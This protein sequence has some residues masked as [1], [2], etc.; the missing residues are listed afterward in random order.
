MQNP[1]TMGRRLKPRRLRHGNRP[2]GRA[3][4]LGVPGTAN[5]FAGRVAQQPL[6]FRLIPFLALCLALAGCSQSNTPSGPSPSGGAPAPPSVSVPTDQQGAPLLPDPKLTPGDALAGVA[7]SDVCV[8]GYTQTVRNVPIELKRQVYAE[9]GIMNHQPG[10]YEVDHLVSLELGG[11]NSI[12]NLWPQS[13]KTQPW[14]AHVKDQLENKL[15]EMICSGQIDMATAQHEIATDWI[16]AYKKYF[17]TDTPLSGSYQVH[18]RRH[19][20]TEE[21]SPPISSPGEPAA[22]PETTA[23]S[24]G[25]VWVNTRSGKYFVS[26]DKYYGNTKEGQYMPEA[27]AQQQGYVPARR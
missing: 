11:S 12:R 13:Y 1:R 21:T 10:D 20:L 5:T 3:G 27:Q 25:Q 16:A 8:S 17:N 9:Y 2:S 14:N 4:G 7:T 22:P 18:N 23:A 26:G 19:P 6:A 15:H 24:N